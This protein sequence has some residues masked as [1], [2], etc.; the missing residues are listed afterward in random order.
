MTLDL[1]KLRAEPLALIDENK[2]LKAELA[3]ANNEFGS[4]T[5]D[6]PDL[7]KRIADLKEISNDR[8][9][10]NERLKSVLREVIRI[11]E[12]QEDGVLYTDDVIGWMMA[13]CDAADLVRAALAEGGPD[14]R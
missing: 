12:N 1:A 10:E 3:K 5:P 11:I 8:W 14:D 7:W 6:W 2:R 4:E 9:R 13:F